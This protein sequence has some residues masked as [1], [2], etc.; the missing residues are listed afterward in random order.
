MTGVETRTVL[1]QKEILKGPRRKVHCS[2]QAD[3]HAGEGKIATSGRHRQRVEADIETTAHDGTYQRR[4]NRGPGATHHHVRDARKKASSMVKGGK[5]SPTGQNSL[6]DDTGGTPLGRRG[7]PRTFGLISGRT[8]PTASIEPVMGGV[9][10]N[11][12][13]GRG[14]SEVDRRPARLRH[15]STF[16]GGGLLTRGK[17]GDVGGY[18]SERP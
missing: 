6:M 5:A 12:L 15:F 2:K 11:D 1:R 9:K 7:P 18:F 8:T 16:A 13:R 3:N 14:V 10:G 4:S 17:G